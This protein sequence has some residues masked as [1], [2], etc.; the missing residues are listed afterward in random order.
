[1]LVSSQTP[2]FS[3]IGF[4]SFLW[5]TLN[6]CP[7]IQSRIELF[8]RFVFFTQ[9]PVKLVI[10]LFLHTVFETPLLREGAFLTARVL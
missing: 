7:V 9:V 5:A 6:F 8:L 3:G 2:A 10:A 1:M 4:P